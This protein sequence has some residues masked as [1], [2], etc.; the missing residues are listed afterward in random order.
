MIDPHDNLSRGDGRG[1]RRSTRFDVVQRRVGFVGKHELPLG[2]TLDPAATVGFSARRPRTSQQVATYTGDG[3]TMVV[4]RTGAGKGRCCAIPWLLHLENSAVVL[5]VK[6][7]AYAV[8]AAHRAAEFGHRIYVLDPFHSVGGTDTLNPFDLVRPDLVDVDADVLAELLVDG[9][10][11]SKV[12]QFWDNMARAFL[13]GCIAHI[14]TASTTPDLVQLRDL[15]QCDDVVFRIAQLLDEKK[16][17][18]PLARREFATFANHEGEKV[19]T[20]VLSTAQQ[21]LRILGTDSVA[22]AIGK[23]TID[24]D[25]VISGDRFTIYIVI[26]PEN[27]VSHGAVLRLWVGVLL[28][29]M[30]R[31][32]RMP[33]S[34]TIFM[35]DE[36]AQCGKLGALRQAITLM[37]GYGV[38]TIT[39][40]QDLAQMQALYED[41]RTLLNNCATLMTFGAANYEMATTIGGIIG[42]APHRLMGLHRDNALV[43]VSGREVF[44]VRRLDYLV[45]R[46]LRRRARRNPRFDRRDDGPEPQA[47]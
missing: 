31:R 42:V 23:S 38:Q 7:E 21:H 39:M 6:G 27:L 9:K 45:D 1:K 12:D 22:R 19:R 4:A 8:T 15:L 37:R 14:A 10:P 20:S 24:L 46:W 13:L 43:H 25:H 5:D 11:P 16:V 17:T 36:I 34:S 28:T 2:Y 18:H 40:W 47:V 3:H 33:D 26:P 35:L 32:K 29:A 30:T 44:E 41:W